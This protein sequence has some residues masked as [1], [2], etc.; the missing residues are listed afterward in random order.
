MDSGYFSA[1]G[2]QL[3]PA[4][5][6]LEQLLDAEGRD[7]ALR[8]VPASPR[9]RRGTGCAP[10]GTGRCAWE[11]LTECAESYQPTAMTTFPVVPRP[12]SARCA[13]GR[14]SKAKRGPR[15]GRMRPSFQSAKTSA[16]HALELARAVRQEREVEAD[17]RPARLDEAVGREEPHRE[18]LA[19]RRQLRHA[20]G[21]RSRGEAIEHVS[22]A[23]GRAAARGAGRLF[24]RWRPRR[25]RRA[26][27]TR[28][29]S[30]SADS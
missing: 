18:Q 5:F 26:R 10:S 15:T 17:Q 9:S 2:E 7:A 14:R 19:R 22:P 25:R 3:R 30:A 20:R 11:H 24:R 6:A 28:S 21:A 13:S 27:R 1:C 8:E 16:R 12:A 4:R 23:K 29:M